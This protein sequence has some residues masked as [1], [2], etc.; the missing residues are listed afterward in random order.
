[1]GRHRSPRE[2][3]AG[4]GWRVMRRGRWKQARKLRRRRL[5]PRL[6]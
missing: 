5:E 1:M 2:V 6:A 3:K 4:K